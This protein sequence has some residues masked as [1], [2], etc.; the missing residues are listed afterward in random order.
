MSHT[1]ITMCVK[2]FLEPEMCDLNEIVVPKVSTKWEDIAYQLH[3]EIPIVDE[4]NTKHKEDPKRC[5]KE[6]FKDWLTTSNGVEP[7][8]WQT[9]LDKLK[10]M[11]DLY[12]ITKDITEE[13]IQMDPEA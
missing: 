4:I 3:Y 1:I 2:C 12:A 9:L 5:C 6:L 7:K 13:L 11:K 8:I 10:K